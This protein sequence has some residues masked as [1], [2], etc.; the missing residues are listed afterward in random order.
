[1]DKCTT[2]V[3]LGECGEKKT[4]TPVYTSSENICT[5]GL[6]S[7]KCGEN[8]G[9]IMDTYAPL[10]VY[11]WYIYILSGSVYRSAHFF[12]HRNPLMIHQWYM[13]P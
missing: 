3:S 4:S 6:S 8:R 5:D 9:D 10:M 7:G 13:C 1:M 2:D 11:H 12:S